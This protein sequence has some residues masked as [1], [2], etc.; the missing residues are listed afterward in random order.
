[1]N[2]RIYIGQTTTT[3]TRRWSSHLF[4]AR[5]GKYNLPLYN[6]RQKYGSEQFRVSEFVE[7]SCQIELDALE[8]KAIRVFRSLAC[9]D[10]YNLSPGGKGG[11]LST[12]TRRKMS[13]ARRGEKHF[14]FGKRQPAHVVEAMRAGSLGRK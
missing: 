12:E 7:A 8:V 14:R 11:K 6:A 2:C 5:R 4:E 10:G 9:Q 3:I 13:D 1:A